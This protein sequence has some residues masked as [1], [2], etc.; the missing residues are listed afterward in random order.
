M[1]AGTY[2]K[3]PFELVPLGVDFVR[4]LLKDDDTVAE[5]QVIARDAMTG[6]LASQLLDGNPLLGDSIILEAG[7]PIRPAT[8]VIQ[9]IMAGVALSDYL[10]TYQITTGQGQQWE[11][12]IYLRVRE[13]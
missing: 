11:G 2:T 12:D 5:I 10:I 3:Q 6:A 7:V 13:P 8:R 1:I 9:R 4:E